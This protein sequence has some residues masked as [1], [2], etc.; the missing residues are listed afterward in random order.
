MRK[1]FLF[2]ATLFVL[3]AVA[4][5]GGAPAEDAV[6]TVDNSL[7]ADATAETQAD[8]TAAPTTD[9]AVV[10]VTPRGTDAFTVPLPGT[11]DPIVTE[12]PNIALVFDRIYLVRTGGPQNSGALEVEI[13]QDG[14]VIR[15]GETQLISPDEVLALDTMLDEIDF[16]GIHGAYLG[17]PT[18]QDEPYRYELRVER[19][20]DRRLIVFQEGYIPD[21]IEA[22]LAAIITAGN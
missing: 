19:A 12:D 6:P 11:L 10:V 8:D 4:A 13:F 18:G 15:N 22:L 7:S 16:F 9:P 2:F 3:V 20:E 21:E 17:P 14:R 5:C 1:S